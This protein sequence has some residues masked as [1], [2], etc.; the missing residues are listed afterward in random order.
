LLLLVQ[1]LGLYGLAGA[2]YLPADL[3]LDDHYSLFNFF[4][5][6]IPLV[7]LTILIWFSCWFSRNRNCT[8]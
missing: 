2:T 8:S 1:K 6:T 4:F 5:S 3:C 7:A